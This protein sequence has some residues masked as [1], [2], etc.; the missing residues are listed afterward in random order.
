MNAWLDHPR[1]KQGELQAFDAER[2]ERRGHLTQARALYHQAAENFEAVALGVPADH[3]N[4]RGDLAIAAVA[5]FARAGDL[6]RAVE[7]ARRMLVEIDALSPHGRGE[8]ERLAREYAGLLVA[9]V[10]PVPDAGSRK[11]TLRATS[12]SMR[13][14]DDVR[15]RARHAQGANR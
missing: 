3:P 10:S 1:T 9:T 5:S 2:A 7:L 15:E 14:R 8:L 13:V 6:G 4:T 12:A 11:G